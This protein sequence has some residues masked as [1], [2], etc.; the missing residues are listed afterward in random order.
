MVFADETSHELGEH[1]RQWVQRPRGTKY[2]YMEKYMCHEKSHDA[3]IHVF[4]YI[5]ANGRGGIDQFTENLDKTLLKKI[6]QRNRQPILH[7][8]PEYV[9]WYF[10]WD[11]DKKHTSDLVREWLHNNGI[12][13]V[14]YPPYSADI[15]IIENVWYDVK[16]RVEARDPKNEQDLKRI[17]QEEWKNTDKMFVMR[18]VHSMPAQCQAIINAQGDHIP[19]II[20]NKQEHANC[21]Q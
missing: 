1:M 14:D 17:W 2:A 9:L 19:F 15:N 18:L 8:F 21:S 11:N 12:T 10:L 6:L 4:G 5:A 13:Q 16:H 20:E 7:V 3:K